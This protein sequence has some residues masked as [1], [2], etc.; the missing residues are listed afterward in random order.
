MYL[1]HE[2]YFTLIIFK[3]KNHQR[4]LFISPSTAKN[5]LDKGPGSGRVLNHRIHIYKGY[6]L[7]EVGRTGAGLG[8]RNPLRAPLPLPGIAKS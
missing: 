8:D 3:N 6:R 4:E 2:D 7:G 1:W 5:T